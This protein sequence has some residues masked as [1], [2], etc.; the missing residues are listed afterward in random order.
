MKK[1][2]KKNALHSLGEMQGGCSKKGSLTR[3]L[4]LCTKK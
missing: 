3:D 1:R 2:H 4:Y